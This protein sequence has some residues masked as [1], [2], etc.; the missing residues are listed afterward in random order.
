MDKS[1]IAFDF[2]SIKHLILSAN[3]QVSN[4]FSIWYVYKSNLPIY[5]I[6]YLLTYYIGR[7]LESRMHLLWNGHRLLRFWWKIRTRNKCCGEIGESKTFSF[8]VQHKIRIWTSFTFN[9]SIIT[10]TEKDK[11]FKP[12]QSSIFRIMIS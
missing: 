9:I 3:I 11:Q 12:I 5:L 4:C 10:L 7:C 6:T 2:S 1:N 8:Y